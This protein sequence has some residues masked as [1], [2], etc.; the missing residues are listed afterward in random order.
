MF[1][2]PAATL[3][4]IS[5]AVTLPPS[6]SLMTMSVRFSAVSSVYVSGALR[7]VALG[8]SL[9]GVTLRVTLVT[10]EDNGPPLPVLP[11]SL[12]DTP[13]VT[14]EVSLSAVVKLRLLA[15]MKVFR[16]AIVPVS[17]NALALPPTTTPPP[18]LAK[19]EPEAAVNVAVTL[20][21][22]ASTS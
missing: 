5:E 6:T 11:P 13:S 8:A 19:S 4:K 17:V 10:P 2:L 18:E 16:F 12:S 15:P 21:P 22:P 20:P 14:A 1:R 3:D 9:T 7:F